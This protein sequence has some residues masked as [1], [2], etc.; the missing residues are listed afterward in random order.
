MI[1]TVSEQILNFISENPG[2]T[3]GEL[4][5]ALGKRRQHINQECNYL[6]KIQKIDRHKNENG[7]YGNYPVAKNTSAK[8]NSL[9]VS[10]DFL[11]KLFR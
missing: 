3:D 7:I 1:A 8:R 9:F 6:S 5:I 10:I 11:K 2:A 4:S